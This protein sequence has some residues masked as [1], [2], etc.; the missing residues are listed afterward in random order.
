MTQGK[1]DTWTNG[2]FSQR[3]EITTKNPKDNVLRLGKLLQTG[4]EGAYVGEKSF[5]MI[6]NGLVKS[7]LKLTAKNVWGISQCW[8]AVR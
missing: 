5:V 2:H 4:K 8:I 6:K 1:E 3:R 7:S